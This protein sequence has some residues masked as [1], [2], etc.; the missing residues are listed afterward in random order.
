MIY[1]IWTR[2][3]ALTTLIVNLQLH[4][5]YNLKW[6]CVGTCTEEA[7]DAE[8]ATQTESDSANGDKKK[9]QQEAIRCIP[10]LTQTLTLTLT[11][12]RKKVTLSHVM[13]KSL[14]PLWRGKA[15]MTP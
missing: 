3:E 5:T 6:Q 14:Q 8:D 15:G 13:N 2:K 9:Q 4:L 12:R 7:V 1:L 11:L 10:T